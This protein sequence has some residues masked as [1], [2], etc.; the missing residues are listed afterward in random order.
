MHEPAR[1]RKGWGHK[2]VDMVGVGGGGQV[3]KSSR[4]SRECWTQMGPAGGSRVSVLR[5]D[6]RLD[7]IWGILGQFAPDQRC[8][9]WYGRKRPSRRPVEVSPLVPLRG[10]SSGQGSW[11]QGCVSVFN[12]VSKEGNS[13]PA[14]LGMKELSCDHR[15][16][17][18][19]LGPSTATC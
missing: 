17:P 4:E 5:A 1:G 14:V 8:G 3:R 6:R 12:R 15:A 9:P 19:S 2:N 18:H 10:K 16:Q 13:Q 7:H 11:Q